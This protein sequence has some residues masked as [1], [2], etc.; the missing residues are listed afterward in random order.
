MRGIVV[1]AIGLLAA[2]ALAA[3]PAAARTQARRVACCRVPAGAVVQV[4]LVEDISTKTARAGDSFALRLSAPLIVGDRILLAAGTPGEGVVISASKPGMGGKPAKLVLAA[5]YLSLRHGQ[6]PLEGLQL[7]SAGRNN[8][9]AA[10]VVGL[11]GFAFAP[12]GYL[13][14]AV[15]GG[16]ATFPKGTTATAKLATD[17][18][19]PPIG[20]ASRAQVAQAQ[21]AADAEDTDAGEGAAIEVPPPPPGQGQ[22]VFFRRKTLLAT[23]Q[24]FKVRENGVALGKLSNGV[25]FVDVTAPG[26]HTYTATMEPEVK[27]HLRLEVDPGET[28]YVE[29]YTTKGVVV[30]IADLS[31]S[32]LE[33]FARASK[34]LKLAKPLATNAADLPDHPDD[35]NAAGYTWAKERIIDEP[36]GC[37]AG[38]A[39][40]RA[41]CLAYVS[42]AT[43][44]ELK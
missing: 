32:S 6:A 33:D 17:M 39:N 24:W 10:S 36:T 29:G 26:I 40:F 43:Q 14:L 13:G 7:A 19:L 44:G 30:G 8:G 38:P 12:L 41:G 9:T 11:T 31:P 3:S 27:D 37:P 28:Y 4:E 42:E 34:R 15:Q 22:V 20:R 16:N 21:E 23:G 35:T 25:Y 2:L 1:S 18:V 5:R